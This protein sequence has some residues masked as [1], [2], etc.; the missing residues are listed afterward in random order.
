[1]TENPL[2]REIKRRMMPLRRSMP[3]GGLREIKGSPRLK[4]GERVELAPSRPRRRS[5]VPQ[6]I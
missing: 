1:M 3:L 6:L 2:Q 4:G 5:I